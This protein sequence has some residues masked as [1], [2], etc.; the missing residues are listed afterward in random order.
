MKRQFNISVGIGGTLIVT[1]FVILCLATVGTL[2]LMTAHSDYK[3]TQKAVEGTEEYYFADGCAEDIL[4]QID[5]TLMETSQA[6]LEDHQLGLASQSEKEEK[7]IEKRTQALE[8]ALPP[9]V[10]IEIEADKWLSY[11]VPI[12]GYQQLNVKLLLNSFD[13]AT[14]Q[15]Y[16]IETWHTES[17]LQWEYEDYEENFEDTITKQIN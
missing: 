10:P 16:Q 9:N 4:K 15:Y 6:I 3:L 12:N 14:N 1:I 2:A 17:L 8:N 13:N 5:E 11:S 7:Y